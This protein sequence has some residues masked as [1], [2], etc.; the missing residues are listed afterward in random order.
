MGCLLVNSIVGAVPGVRDEPTCAMVRAA[1][2]GQE[3]RSPASN[4]N[5]W[6]CKQGV[7]RV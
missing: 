7:K 3:K 4:V 2:M 6:A 1:H 5:E